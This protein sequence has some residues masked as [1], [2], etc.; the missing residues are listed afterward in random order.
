MVPASTVLDLQVNYSIPK[1]KSSIKIGGANIGGKEYTSAPGTGYI[2]SQYFA[3]W[4][5]SL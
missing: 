4:T 2:G 3:S 1:W 5:I